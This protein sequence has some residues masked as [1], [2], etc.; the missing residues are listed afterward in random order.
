MLVDFTYNNL[1]KFIEVRKYTCRCQGRGLVLGR[2]FGELVFN[3][4]K[5]SV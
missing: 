2:G 5:V 3:G 4:N 1:V